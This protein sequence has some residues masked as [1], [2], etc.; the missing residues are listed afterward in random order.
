MYILC[1]TCSI[2]MLLR[3]A[4]DMF[5]NKEYKCLTLLDVRKEMFQK[6][7]FKNKYPWRSKFKSNVS[8][9]PNSEL[10]NNQDFINLK[11]AM[12]LLITR[13]VVNEETGR[14]FDLSRVDIK[15]LACAISY[16]HKVASGDNGLKQFAHQEFS[17]QYKG[18]IS[19]LG[20]I[21]MWLRKGI[22]AWNDEKQTYLTEW[23]L[24]NEDPQ[25]LLQRRQFKRLTGYAYPGS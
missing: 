14:L 19:P 7:T 4:P 17:D 10:N 15:I 24:L 22:I 8:C 9:I 12:N 3:I 1:D 6:Q 11:K 16:G 18:D 2:L 20:I 21:N 5:N 23:A 25:P 13:G